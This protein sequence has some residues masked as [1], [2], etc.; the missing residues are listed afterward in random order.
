MSREAWFTEDDTVR[1]FT[2]RDQLSSSVPG[3]QLWHRFSCLPDRPQNMADCPVR[4]DQTA[5]INTVGRNLHD[6]DMKT[7]TPQ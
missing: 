2:M 1:D 6:R 3:G 5:F 7:F 4:G